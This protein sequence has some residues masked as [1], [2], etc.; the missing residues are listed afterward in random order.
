MKSQE[1]FLFIC[2]MGMNIQ[3]TAQGDLMI[4]PKRVV[5]EG[6]KQREELTLINLGK[7]TTTFSISFVQKMMKENGGF[8]TIEKHDSTLLIAEPFLRIF[9]RQVT[10]APGEPQ[11]IMVQC[12]RIA[13]MQPGE[14]RSHLYFRSEKDYRPLGTKNPFKDST[15]VD[16]QLIPIYGMSIPIIIRSGEV[17]VSTSLNNLKL[18]TQKDTLQILQL[19]INRTGN[20]SAY[21]NLIVEYT[22]EQGKPYQVGI[23]KSVGVYTNIDKR[24][25]SIRLNKVPGLVFKKGNLK[26][27]YTSPDF[28]KYT[29]YAEGILPIEEQTGITQ[30]GANKDNEQ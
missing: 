8:E 13:N 21:G 16:I 17:N 19:T 7:D 22:P 20:C 14:Y 29:V 15:L 9:P 25:V 26:V 6:N 10:L 12:R 23:A 28:A 11:V 18:E 5:F 30:V 1:L 2:L 24:N 3:A 27:R 4:T